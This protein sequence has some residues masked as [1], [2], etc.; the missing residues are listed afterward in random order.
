MG[1][2]A[3]VDIGWPFSMMVIDD[4]SWPFG[5]GG[6]STFWSRFFF[7]QSKTSIFTTVAGQTNSARTFQRNAQFDPTNFFLQKTEARKAQVEVLLPSFL[8]F[9]P[10]EDSPEGPDIFNQP[11]VV[12]LRSSVTR[13]FSF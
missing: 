1:V 6:I 7:F 13:L 5:R 12:M 10:S 8:F 3:R 2:D 9:F 11:R 4:Q